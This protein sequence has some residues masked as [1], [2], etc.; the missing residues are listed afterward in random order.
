MTKHAQKLRAHSWGAFTREQREAILVKQRAVE[1][2][3]HDLIR[4]G[5]TDPME[6]GK[7]GITQ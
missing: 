4:F 1:E 3:Q 7:D 6:G 5:A 2:N